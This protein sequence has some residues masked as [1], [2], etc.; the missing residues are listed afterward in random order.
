MDFT[1]L[2]YLHSQTLIEFQLQRAGPEEKI[3]TTLSRGKS[4]AAFSKL[5]EIYSRKEAERRI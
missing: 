2:V 3:G 4:T 1:N 5:E